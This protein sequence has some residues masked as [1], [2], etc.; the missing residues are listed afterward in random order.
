MVVII[1][2]L[3]VILRRDSTT[4]INNKEFSDLT[5]A[6]LFILFIPVNTPLSQGLRFPSPP[7]AA[8]PPP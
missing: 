8:A 5:E 7:S 4:S 3:F 2:R 1:Q 6:N